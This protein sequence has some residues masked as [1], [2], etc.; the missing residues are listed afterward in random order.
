MSRKLT[1][2]FLQ[3]RVVKVRWGGGSR[4]IS[5]AVVLFGLLVLSGGRAAP[6]AAELRTPCARQTLR[7]TLRLRSDISL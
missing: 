7:S 1:L 4:V 6:L 5:E 2:W 3:H